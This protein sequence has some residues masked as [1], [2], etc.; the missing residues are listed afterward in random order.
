MKISPVGAQFFYA[1]RHEKANFAFRNF[2]KAAKTNVYKIPVTPNSATYI[3]LQKFFVKTCYD[4][5]ANT[6][7]NER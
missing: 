6:C 3:F 7:M 1:E 2:A 5:Y 4:K